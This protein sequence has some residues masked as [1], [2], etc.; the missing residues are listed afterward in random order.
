MSGTAGI[1]VGNTV[2][3]PLFKTTGIGL[4]LGKALNPQTTTFEEAMDQLFIS[5]EF[6]SEAG[7]S[8]KNMHPH[9]YQ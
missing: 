6:K 4:P 3:A 2:A 8:P 7:R 5:C 9:Q 1:K